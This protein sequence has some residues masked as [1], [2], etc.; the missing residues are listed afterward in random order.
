MPFSF[1]TKSIISKQFPCFITHTNQNTH[2]IILKNFQNSPL[3]DGSIVSRGPR[4]CP[5]IEDKVKRFEDREKHQVFLEPETRSGELIYP[6]GISTSLD[7]NSQMKFL[8]TINGLENVIVEDFGYAV[9]YDC[10]DS[11]ELELTYESK[12]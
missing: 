1:L 8:R 6:N 4:Y 5:S 2:K 11:N 7:E 9:E 3:F 12:K 10:V